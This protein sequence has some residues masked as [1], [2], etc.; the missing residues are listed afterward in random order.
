MIVLAEQRKFFY[1]PH[2]K[3][4]YP[5]KV[6][7]NK[8]VPKGCFYETCEI[9]PLV[10]QRV[11]DS[12]MPS[13]E[14]ITKNFSNIP[15]QSHIKFE[16]NLDPTNNLFGYDLSGK[17]R[18][19]GFYNFRKEELAS[20]LN[21]FEN[22]SSLSNWGF[23]IKINCYKEILNDI[24]FWSCSLDVNIRKEQW[25][26]KSEEKEFLVWKLFMGDVSI[27]IEERVNEDVVE[28]LLDHIEEKLSVDYKL[29]Y[30]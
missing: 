9:Y 2:G 7:K 8:Q 12:I 30:C 19:K 14:A 11:I 23:K 24:E 4:M 17:H 20:I 27:N 25:I 16:T 1:H 10:R 18:I 13:L 3:G 5:I 15:F 28:K 29:H 22:F 26:D 6:Y 21:D